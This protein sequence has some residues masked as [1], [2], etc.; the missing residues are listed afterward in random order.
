MLRDD[1][2]SRLGDEI[3]EP[4]PAE[5]S[6]DV[7]GKTA[8]RGG[9]T[10]RRVYL[11]LSRYYRIDIRHRRFSNSLTPEAIIGKRSVRVA[12]HERPSCRCSAAMLSMC[13]NSK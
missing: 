2:V 6:R 13:R 7:L 3:V 11:E 8:A 9:N 5:L 1:R 12:A 4:A 10:I